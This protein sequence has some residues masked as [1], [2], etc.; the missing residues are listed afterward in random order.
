[1]PEQGWHPGRG[2]GNF[3]RMSGLM[4]ISVPLATLAFFILG[5]TTGG[6]GW[7]WIVFLIPPILRAYERGGRRNA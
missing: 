4:A 1:M 5:F 7:A 3:D 6:W 2:A